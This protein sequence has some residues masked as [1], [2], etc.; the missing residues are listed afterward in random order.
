M[1]R[2]P[3]L[4]VQS[5]FAAGLLFGLLYGCKQKEKKA[6]DS[7][8]N[9]N[10]N[11]LL[12][13]TNAYVISSIPTT[14]LTNQEVSPEI[15]APGVV[16]Y[17]TRQV[18][19]IAARVA[20]RIDRLYV[21]YKYQEIVKGQKIMDIYSP[22]LMTLQENL[23]FLLK[24]D[25]LNSVMISA[26]KERLLILGMSENQLQLIVKSHQLVNSITIYSNYSGHIHEAGMDSNMGGSPGGM[27]NNSVLTEPLSIKEGSYLQKGQQVFS[28]YN[29][30]K[31]WV[32]LSIYA[33]DQDR[34]KTGNTVHV[35]SDAAGE[36]IYGKIDFIEPFYGKDIKTMTARVYFNNDKLSIPVGRQVK[37][38]VYGTKKIM[39]S[40]PAGSV[41]SL[42]MDQVVFK[43]VDDGF[44]AQKVYI[45]GTYKGRVQIMSGLSPIDKVAVSAQFLMDSESF[46]QVKE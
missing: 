19:V 13:P 20:G 36:I 42:G 33:N 28:I 44:M 15:D 6:A 24:N 37:A 5:L 26:S 14:T 29:T 46:T 17:D 38:T 16:A 41:L 9:I 27:K 7:K 4:F 23:L 34:I 12:K 39:S 32:L 22:E 35:S 40:V 45:G 30:R 25:P 8:V 18:G 31:V 3:N 1:K 43:K 21:Q 11:S 2:S 10:L